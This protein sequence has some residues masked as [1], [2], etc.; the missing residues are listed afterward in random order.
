MVARQGKTGKYPHGAP[1]GWSPE[2]PK[3]SLT[4]EQIDSCKHILRHAGGLKDARRKILGF[5]RSHL[6]PIPHLIE[7]RIN[8]SS[9]QRE[10]TAVITP[11][12]YHTIRIDLKS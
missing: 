5:L 3:R 7:C 1:Q 6:S 9:H 4:K 2:N 11:L 12:A 10:R 8:W